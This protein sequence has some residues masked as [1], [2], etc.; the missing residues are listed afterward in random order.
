ML[1]RIWCLH[2]HFLFLKCFRV[3]HYSV[4]QS[5]NI[6]TSWIALRWS[7]TVPSNP[8][9]VPLLE[10]LQDEAL[11]CQ[12]IQEQSH[13]FNCFKMN[14]YSAKQSKNSAAS[15]NSLRWTLQC[16]PI[17]RQCLFLNCFKMKQYSPSKQEEVLTQWYI[18]TSQKT[19]NFAR[20]PQ[21]PR[22]TSRM[23]LYFS[24]IATGQLNGWCQHYKDTSFRD[25][26]TKKM[27]MLHGHCAVEATWE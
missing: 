4:K 19:W 7:T 16:Q 24:I 22:L 20:P 26:V 1:E 5:K 6:A 23:K 11:Q 8:R 18:I 21:I 14:H 2:L 10:L 17:Q 9:T 27:I 15:W 25:T 12:A 3:K 13:F